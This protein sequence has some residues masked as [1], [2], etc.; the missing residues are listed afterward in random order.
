MG[1]GGVV[2]TPNQR[3]GVRNILSVIS[4]EDMSKVTVKVRDGKPLRIGD[5]ANIVEGHP[6][7]IGDGIVND[8]PGLLLIVE[9]FP[10]ANTL[11]VTQEVEKALEALKPGLPG[12]AIDSTIF[13]PATFIQMSIDNLTTALIIGSIL[14]VLILV[15]F[16]YEWRV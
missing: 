12:I 11:E 8:G 15:A 7:M 2:D 1:T 3:L 9:K 5:V 16:L 14:V 13:R 4:A 10:W 6:P